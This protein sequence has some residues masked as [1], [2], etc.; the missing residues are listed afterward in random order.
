MKGCEIEGGLYPPKK[1]LPDKSEG[2]PILRRYPP[3]YPLKKENE[4]SAMDFR[5]LRD[6]VNFGQK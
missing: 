3:P 5:K 6:S 1:G 4:L 2:F